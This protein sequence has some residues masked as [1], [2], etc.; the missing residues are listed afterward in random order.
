VFCTY[1]RENTLASEHHDDLYRY[2]WGIVKKRNC[3]LYRINGTENHIHI[4]SDLHPSIS[5]ADFIKEIKTASNTWMKNS[6][7]FPHFTSWAEGYCALTYS[8]RD[9]DMVVNY[10]KR[11]KEH[12]ATQSFEDEYRALLKEFSIEADERYIF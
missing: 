11:Q 7:N 12:H 1:R 2:I 3:V 8:L 10:I 6:G 4:L 9:K 5:L